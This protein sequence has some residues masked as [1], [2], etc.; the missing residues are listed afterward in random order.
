MSARHAALLMSSTGVLLQVFQMLRQDGD[1]K[2]QAIKQAEKDKKG[3]AEAVK[4]DLLK[5]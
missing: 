5:V 4:G 3:V 1:K 2:N